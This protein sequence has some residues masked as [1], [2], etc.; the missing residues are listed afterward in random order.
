MNCFY[1][2]VWT[3]F[4]FI[5]LVQ[6]PLAAQTADDGNTTKLEQ[7]DRLYDQATES[8]RNGQLDEAMKLLEQ[9]YALEESLFGVAHENL[10]ETLGTLAQI[11]EITQDSQAGI[12]I[13]RRVH[14]ITEQLYGETD[15]RTQDAQRT[16][17][18]AQ[19][20]AA[21]SPED[22]TRLQ[23]SRKL[24]QDVLKLYNEGKYSVAISVA[25]QVA[26]T[27]KT[28]LGERHTEYAKSLNHLGMLYQAT[29]NYPRAEPLYVQAMEIVKTVLGE[30]HPDYATSLNNLALLY[31][32]IG[33]YNRAMPLI[34]QAVDIRKLLLGEQHPSYGSSLAS[35]ARI[36]QAMGDYPRAEPLYLQSLEIAKASHGEQHPDYAS[37]LHN[38]AELY[39]LMGDYTR[40]EPLYAQAAEIIKGLFGEQHPQY[41]A[42]LFN[43]GVLYYSMGDYPRAEPLFVQA[44]EILKVVVGEQ[45][46]DYATGLNNLAELY[47][48]MEDYP[49][50]ETILNQ[51]IEIYKSVLGEQHPDYAI[52]L[53]NLAE[54]YRWMNDYKRA[55]PL[56]VQAIKIW[57]SVLGDQHPNYAR[58]ISNLASLYYSM[59]QYKQ[60][61]PLFVRATE[62]WKATLGDQHPLYAQSTNNLAVLYARMRDYT[63]AEPLFVVA[64]ETTRRNLD[65]TAS[66]QTES[67]QIAMNHSLRYQ[68]DNAIGCSLEVGSQSPMIIQNVMAWKGS[69]FVRL[70]GLRLAAAD[71]LIADSFKA[72]QVKSQRLSALTNSIP[73]PENLNTWR[74]QVAELTGEKEKLDT[75]LMRD[76]T[77]FRA[78]QQKVSLDEVRQAIPKGGTIVNYLEYHETEK[79]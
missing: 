68:L 66:V 78:A 31:D 43:L 6:N 39:R 34:V 21:R 18:D 22:H 74:E 37:S 79:R 58:G 41:A 12:D 54:L 49:R 5:G 29:G 32:A 20:N 76:S 48:L 8:T 59:R 65:L 7:R 55:E 71:P 69:V 47:R 3:F 46:P 63:R 10:L 9:V 64:I 75:Q 33:D 2:M 52:G 51:A 50:A 42:C 16:I 30:Q 77:A 60:A 53:N 38:L 61:E 25:K 44:M 26:E 36:Y 17:T 62:I 15:Y 72:L 19:Q 14:R 35:L 67:Q 13:H 23:Q 45:H 27:R 40:A 28:V 24:S 70:R 1:V 4:V 11:A 57:K 56:Y 73:V